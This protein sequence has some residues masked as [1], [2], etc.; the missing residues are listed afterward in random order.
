MRKDVIYTIIT[1]ATLICSSC[2]KVDPGEGVPVVTQVG[3][4]PINHFQ[5][6][7]SHNSYHLLPNQQIFDSL[8]TIAQ[9]FPDS[10]LELDYWHE[11]FTDQL[12]TYGV[13]QFELDVYNDPDG[14]H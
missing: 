8:L 11:S 13:R 7:G 6:I 2:D 12:E 3:D 5:V 9:V 10:P 14:G 1:L 4:L